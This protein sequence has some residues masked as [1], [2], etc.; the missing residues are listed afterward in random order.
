MNTHVR[1]S[2]YDAMDLMDKKIDAAFNNKERIVLYSAYETNYDDVTDDNIIDNLDKIAINGEC[3]MTMRHTP[4]FGPG[5]PYTSDLLTD[6]TWL[7]LTLLANQMMEITGD[8]H[9]CFFEGVI[10]VSDNRYEFIMGS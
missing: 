2:Y 1:S 4:L 8:L 6:P 7:D 5:E 3:I 9:H 10:L